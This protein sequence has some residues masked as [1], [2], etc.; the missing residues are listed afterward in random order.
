MT[1]ND[2]GNKYSSE[3]L[4]L[5]SCIREIHIPKIS[6]TIL[7]ILVAFFAV[8]IFVSILPWRQFSSGY[9]KITNLDPNDRTQ[10]ITA[11]VNGTVKWHVQDGQSV[12]EGDVIAEVIDN[13][14]DIVDNIRRE[15][16]SLNK[17]YIAMQEVS[18]TSKIN[19][20]RQKDLFN[21]GISS[22]RDYEKAKMEYQ[23]AISDVNYYQSLLMKSNIALARQKRQVIT[24]HTN[25]T[26]VQT[27]A[28]SDN[29]I[30]KSGQS[31]ATFVPDNHNFIAEIFVD[32]NDAPLIAVGQ[33][34]RLQFEGWP[35][36]QII[37]WPSIAMGTFGGIVSFVDLSA[38]NDG[39]YRVLISE[40]SSDTR[41]PSHKF[42]RR[43]AKVNGWVLLNQVSIGYEVWRKFNGFPLSVNYIKNIE[44][45]FYLRGG[46]D[47]KK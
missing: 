15:N 30:V 40:D 44:P 13:D 43:G 25:G 10:Y 7:N 8:C 41:W 42:L 37:G 29:T 9:G 22:R 31:I 27:L 23:K 18:Q 32:A 35:A 2:E 38:Q 3:Q 4:K 33:K 5:F 12:Q 17:R 16:A 26:V 6:Q 34:A 1:T 20:L 39:T 24:A 45:S 21:L 36:V 28:A 11:N 46:S 19:Y 47:G 14:K